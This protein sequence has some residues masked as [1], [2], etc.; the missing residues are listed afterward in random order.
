MIVIGFN[1][2]RL[3]TMTRP[4]GWNCRVIVVN[5]RDYTGLWNIY[6][7]EVENDSHARAPTLAAYF[8]RFR[9]LCMAAS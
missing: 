2:G 6:I 9:V 8:P 1:R 4:G 3:T 5:G 7:F